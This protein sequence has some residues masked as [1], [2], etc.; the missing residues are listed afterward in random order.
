MTTGGTCGPEGHLVRPL[1]PV[2]P[3]LAFAVAA[4]VLVFA[5][6]DVS[7]GVFAALIAGVL[8]ASLELVQMGFL[9]LPVVFLSAAIG[10][11]VR[12]P[13]PARIP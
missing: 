13:V 2:V 1:P 3:L 10:A 7:Q 8:M 5:P 4:Q 9:T 6:A 12:P 11:A